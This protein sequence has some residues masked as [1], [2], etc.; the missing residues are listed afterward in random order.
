MQFMNSNN[1]SFNF[2]DATI[3]LNQKFAGYSPLNDRH[4]E[5][6]LRASRMT[7]RDINEREEIIREKDSI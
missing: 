3:D 5:Q 2:G 4:I 7:L 6:V 1:D